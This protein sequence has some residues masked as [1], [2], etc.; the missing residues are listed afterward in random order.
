MSQA[1]SNNHLKFGFL[2]PPNI[3]LYPILN[4][5]AHI[6]L[7]LLNLF[8][9]I[10]QK[11][12][13]FV[14]NGVSTSKTNNSFYHFIYLIVFIQQQHGNNSRFVR[15]TLL[16]V[17]AL[18]HTSVTNNVSY[19]LQKSVAHKFSKRLRKIQKAG[20]VQLPFLPFN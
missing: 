9:L 20:E 12:K 13:F 14:Q 10:K 1:S 2:F 3:S 19:L 8:L 5:I 7:S 4:Y 6:L 16:Y 11:Q 17:R 15:F 18:L